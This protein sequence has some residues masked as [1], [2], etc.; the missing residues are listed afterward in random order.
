MTE[1]AC[2]SA[3]IV[4][5]GALR[6]V[7][8]TGVLDGFLETGFNPFDFYLG[9]SSGASNLAAYLAGMKGRNA[10]IYMDYSLRPPFIS[11][12]RFLRGGHLLDLDWLWEITIRKIRL[13]MTRIYASGKPFI[14]V[15]TNVK[16]GE[17]Y[18]KMT[19]PD[20]LE[21][22]LKAS[23]AMPLLYRKYPR[24]DGFPM[25]DGGV[26][27]ALPVGEAIRRGARRIMVIRSRCRGYVKSAGVSE[28]LLC[29]SVRKETKLRQAMDLRVMRYNKALDLLRKPP[30]GVSIVEICPPDDFRVS[31]L[32]KDLRILEEGYRQGKAMAKEAMKNWTPV[33]S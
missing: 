3:L 7:F 24:I 9:V 31:R 23:S 25:T 10:R 14:V 6:G 8:S 21:E 12:F 26:T 2:P 30:P 4:E 19:G 28:K 13:D 5:G 29:R 33:M 16:T 17:A 1:P 20:D 32:S 27:D 11:P 15:M 22:S 18:Y